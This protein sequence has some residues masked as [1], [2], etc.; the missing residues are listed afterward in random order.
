MFIALCML[1]LSSTITFASAPAAS[2]SAAAA[3]SELSIEQ[4]QALYK[5]DQFLTRDSY[6]GGVNQEDWEKKKR[7]IKRMVTKHN[8]PL[9]SSFAGAYVSFPSEHMLKHATMHDDASF[10]HYL[11]NNGVAKDQEED[12]T[13]HLL[14]DARSPKVARALTRRLQHGQKIAQEYGGTLLKEALNTY[15]RVH[16]RSLST[17]KRLELIRYYLRRHVDPQLKTMNAFIGAC[18]RSSQQVQELEWEAQRYTHY[19]EQN[20]RK[21]ERRQETQRQ[22]LLAANQAQTSSA[23]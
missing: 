11:L 4:Q 22:Q 17:G 18:G 1:L 21:R 20:Q 10:I 13:F 2:S 9:R 5:I 14:A 19:K 7:V 6:Q 23:A 15:W 3:Q 12:L 16:S 8:I